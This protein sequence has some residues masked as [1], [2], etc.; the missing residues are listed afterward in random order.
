MTRPGDR[1]LRRDYWLVLST[2]RSSTSAEDIAAV[3]DAHLDWMLS[4]EESGVLVMSGPLLEGP[5]V[6]PGSGVTVL[7]AHDAG[8]AARIAG[9]DPFVI[10]SLRTFDVFL[11]QVGE[12]SIG[13]TVSLGTGTYRWH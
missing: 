9:Q 6:G 3:V 2:P 7:R 5:G 12:G 8:E 10:A 4:L 1:L 13:V 11:W